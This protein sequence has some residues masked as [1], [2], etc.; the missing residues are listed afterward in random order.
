[1]NSVLRAVLSAA[2]GLMPRIVG[3]SERISY[4]YG[5]LVEMRC[6]PGPG[7]M[8]FAAGDEQ[9]LTSACA[10]STSITCRPCC[11]WAR[12]FT[13]STRPVCGSTRSASMVSDTI[14]VNPAA[15]GR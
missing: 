2:P 11:C 1:M 9:K 14:D 6:A 12:Q 15:I 13:V 3:V 10:M 7:E 4:R 5:Q 8:A